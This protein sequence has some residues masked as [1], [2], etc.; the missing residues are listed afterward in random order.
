MTKIVQNAINDPV[1]YKPKDG[2]GT[3]RVKEA[4]FGDDTLP[5]LCL[6]GRVWHQEDIGFRLFQP[7]PAAIALMQT[8]IGVAF[9]GVRL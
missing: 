3:E 6:G 4:L 1:Q 7:A 8:A 5:Q 2:D 9:L